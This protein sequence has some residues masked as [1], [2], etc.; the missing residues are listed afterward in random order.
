MKFQFHFSSNLIKFHKDAIFLAID[1][2]NTEIIK[3][4]IQNK[5]ID[6]NIL[7]VFK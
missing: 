1:K 7:C 5:N 2:E 4:L 3:L 6:I